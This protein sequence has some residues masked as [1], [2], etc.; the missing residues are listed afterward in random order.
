M[1][2]K[3]VLVSIERDKVGNVDFIFGLHFCRVHLKT[4]PLGPLY[5]AKQQLLFEIGR[6]L[7]QKSS[8]RF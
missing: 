8:L 4:V 5:I 7:A 2:N 6:N 3:K 1:C